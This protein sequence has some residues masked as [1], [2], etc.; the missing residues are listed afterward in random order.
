L[1]KKN[2]EKSVRALAFSPDGTKIASGG[3]DTCIRIWDSKSGEKRLEWKHLSADGKDAQSVQFLVFSPD[4]TKIASEGSYSSPQLWDSQLW[5][6]QLW[7]SQSG[8]MLLRLGS[9]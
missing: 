2:L 7:E 6:S 9:R 4:G 3:D 1:S 8:N 5:D